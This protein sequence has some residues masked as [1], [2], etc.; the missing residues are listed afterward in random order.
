MFSISFCDKFN[1]SR[2]TNSRKTFGST[3][4]IQ[5]FKIINDFLGYKKKDVFVS[6]VIIYGITEVKEENYEFMRFLEDENMTIDKTGEKINII[7]N[8]LRNIREL[9]KIKI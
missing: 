4:I 9:E 3:E 2:L 8:E 7:F 1:C 6:N 5:Y